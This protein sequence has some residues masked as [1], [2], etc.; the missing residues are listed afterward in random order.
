MFRYQTKRLIETIIILAKTKDL[1]ELF[2]IKLK[3]INTHL[4]LR[5][6]QIGNTKSKSSTSQ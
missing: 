3:K 2:L 4:S 1:F 5:S 6:S